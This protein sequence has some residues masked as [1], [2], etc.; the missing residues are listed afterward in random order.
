M[1]L[2]YL[3]IETSSLKASDGI[4][5]AIG[6]MPGEDPEVRFADSLEEERRALEWLKSKL[7]GCDTLVTWYGSGFDIPFLV[8]RALFHSMDISK[9]TEIPMLDLHEWSR[10]NLLLGSYSLES[11]SRFLGV[12][13]F[14][15]FKGEDIRALFRM[16]ER[17][18][19][20][21]RKLI[22][23]HCRDDIIMLKSVH[24][25]LKAHVDRSR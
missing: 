4:V 12:G 24:E 11:V 9:L 2:A 7:E 22:V 15:D 8:T 16:V 25:R 1:V 21:A 13:K 19:V 6:L 3:D 14:K 20:E 17:G 23:D 18:N 5:I 10:A